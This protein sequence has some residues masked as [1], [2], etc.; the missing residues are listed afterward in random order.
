MIATLLIQG[1]DGMPPGTNLYQL[2]EPLYGYEFL[3]VCAYP[4][5]NQTF[6]VGCNSEGFVEEQSMMALYHSEHVPHETA[7]A[8]CGYEEATL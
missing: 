7:L 6:I 3:D 1:V 4:A 8:A 2:D 5:E